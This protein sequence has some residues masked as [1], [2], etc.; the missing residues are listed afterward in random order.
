[1]RET[2]AVVQSLSRLRGCRSSC[3]VETESRTGDSAVRLYSNRQPVPQIGM[4]SIISSHSTNSSDTGQPKIERAGELSSGA[5]SSGHLVFFVISAAAPLTTIVGFMALAFILGGVTTPIG[6][7][8]AGLAYGLFAVGFT[9][10]SRYVRSAGAFYA[11]ITLGFGRRVGA[12]SALVG[13]VAYALG[14]VGFC[15]AAGVFASSAVKSIFGVSVSWTLCALVIGVIVGMVAYFRVTIGARVLAVFLLCESAILCVLLGAIL[16]NGTPEGLSYDSFRPTEWDLSSLSSLFVIAFIVYVGFEQTAVYSEEVRDPAR[17]IPRATYLSVGIL[18]TVYTIASWLL[19]MA[20]GPKAL[21]ATLA[22]GDPSMLV[23]N[24]TDR[25]LGSITTDVMQVLI[26]S[27]FFAGVLALHN[28]AA[29]YMFALG[30]SN[31]LPKSLAHTSIRSGSPVAAVAVQTVVLL[32]LLVAF[33]IAGADPYRQIILWTNTP[34]LVGVLALQILTSLA[35]V[36]FFSRRSLAVGPWRSVVAPGLSA[37]ILA[38]VLYLVCSKMNLLTELSATGNLLINI[39]LFVAFA[40][41]FVRAH[42]LSGTEQGV[43]EE[44]VKVE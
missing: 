28:A 34:S 3:D 31:L 42:W 41:G 25:Y 24:I 18:A 6:Y 10:M 5:I 9:A 15:A 21:S 8:M 30:R 23:F 13:Y 35:V 39:P 20:V 12:G 19:L 1:M 26:V 29:R 27:S 33:A 22:T 4:G 43:P 17:T 7:L 16:V 2:A 44:F 36:R 40:V 14:E 32:A 37:L 38:G 11:Y